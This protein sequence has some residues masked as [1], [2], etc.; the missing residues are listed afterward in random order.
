MLAVGDMH[1]SLVTP[2]ERAFEVPRP[3][4]TTEGPA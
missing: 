1:T 3:V 2:E 4:F